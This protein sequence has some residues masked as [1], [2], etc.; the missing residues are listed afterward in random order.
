MNT[1]KL[2]KGALVGFIL[3]VIFICGGC[4]STSTDESETE[5][6]YTPVALYFNPLEQICPYDWVKY[7]PI[8]ENYPDDRT[9][10]GLH[11]SPVAVRNQFSDARLGVSYRL[12]VIFNPDGGLYATLN[13]AWRFGDRYS[14]DSKGRLLE[15]IRYDDNNNYHSEDPMSSFKY[16][17]S[18]LEA[19]VGPSGTKRDLFPN[20]HIKSYRYEY[21]PDS[22]LKAVVPIIDGELSRSASTGSYEFNEQGQLIKMTAPKSANPFLKPFAQPGFNVRSEAEFQYNDKGLC[23]TKIEKLIITTYR[24]GKQETD[25]LSAVSHYQYNKNNDLQRWVYDGVIAEEDNSGVS[26]LTSQLTIEY[27]YKYDDH[28]NWT[29]VWCIFPKDFESYSA[30][31]KF[32]RENT[33]RNGYY[34]DSDKYDGRLAVQF[35]RSISGYYDDLSA[36][37]DVNDEVVQKT[38]EKPK[39]TGAMAYGLQ[40]PVKVVKNEKEKQTTVFNKIGN[41]ESFISANGYRD[42]NDTYIYE[43]PLRYKNGDIQY[44]I[45]ITGNVMRMICE[46]D[47]EIFEFE[48]EYKFD[49]QGRVI[50][51]EWHDG[52]SPVTREFAYEGD[53]RLPYKET[54]S[55][56]D[57]TGDW[58]TT[59]E[60][61]Y[62]D[63]DKHGNWTKRIGISRTVSND[64][65]E[66]QNEDGEY[67]SRNVTRESADTV[68]E[69]RTISYY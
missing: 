42:C 4:A 8:F 3:C 65:E 49:S 41:I 63:V 64:Y 29:T 2:I 24:N 66:E 57:E 1:L 51:H 18:R 35:D 37:E 6:F 53:S 10:Y 46:P 62:I 19:W 67:E 23:N 22:T 61:K 38:D 31:T 60:Y 7:F 5:H 47:D 45:D 54:E 15:I 34:T 30:L 20:F 16:D 48:D 68:E 44:R 43:S 50:S 32:Y 17:G 27:D 9:K 14:Y 59:I 39:Y 33:G 25:T 11:S 52:M 13:S 26:T 56:F 12:E 36:Q 40:G 58:S 55:S 28:G 21:S 69:A